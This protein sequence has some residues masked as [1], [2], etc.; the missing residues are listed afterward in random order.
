LG[1]IEVVEDK[2]KCLNLLKQSMHHILAR[3]V[4]EVSSS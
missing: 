1:V 2:K 3:S 4:P